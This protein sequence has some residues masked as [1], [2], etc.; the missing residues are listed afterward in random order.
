MTLF[1]IPHSV[2]TNM[3][4]SALHLDRRRLLRLL[5]FALAGGLPTLAS[6][7]TPDEKYPTKGV[8]II[9]PYPAGSP[10]DAV[11]RYAAEALQKATGQS[12]VVE[13]VTGAGGTIGVA[14]AV[15]APADGYTLLAQTTGA[16]V[17]GPMLYKSAG[18]DVLRDLK[19]VWG[20]RSAG[21]VLVVPP[22]S[23]FKTLEDLVTQARKAPGK[24]SFATAGNGSPQHMAAELLSNATGIKL[25]NVPYRGAV[26]SQVAL[27]GAEVDMLF[28]S[29]AGALPQIAGGKF[30]ALAVLRKSRLDAL[31]DVPTMQEAGFAAVQMPPSAIGLFVR[32]PVA[33]ADME[34]LATLLSKAYAADTQVQ[35]RLKNLGLSDIT[36]GAPF[37]AQVRDEAAFYKQLIQTSNITVG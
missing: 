26:P 31:P 14:A 27:M 20:L 10:I 34:R 15:R 19:P 4:A 17:C 30:R 33:E 2:G 6:A 7:S 3:N 5:G 13:S 16:L 25:M 36:A 28:D 11:G 24:L 29:I 32:Q 9:N 12:F 8:R 18:Y 1:P 22:N 35:A 23:P 21:L 37:A